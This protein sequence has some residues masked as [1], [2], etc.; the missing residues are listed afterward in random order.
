MLGTA[1]VCTSGH[2]GLSRGVISHQRRRKGWIYTVA[3]IAAE[4]LWPTASVA[5]GTGRTDCTVPR[6]GHCGS[7]SGG[8][9][10]FVLVLRRGI[11]KLRKNDA[12]RC[13]QLP[14][15]PESPPTTAG[16]TQPPPY[17]RRPCMDAVHQLCAYVTRY[18]LMNSS[19]APVA[20]GSS[21]LP[22]CIKIIIFNTKSII[23]TTNFI[24]FNAN[25]HRSASHP[26]LY[27]LLT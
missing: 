19:P 14:L 12:N 13:D 6:S 21:P 18:H 10:N 20:T 7:A 2:H 5:S 24:D 11:F 25:R 4:R 3:S 9:G 23:F 22:I 8:S 27:I 26:W 15:R 17:L 16:P 1:C